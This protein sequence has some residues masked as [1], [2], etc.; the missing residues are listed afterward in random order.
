MTLP[1]FKILHRVSTQLAGMDFSWRTKIGA[2]FIITHGWGLVVNE[3]SHIGKNVTLFHG[4]TLG[5]NGRKGTDGKITIGYP[6]LEDEV[7]VGPNA[8]IVGGVTIG[9][10]SRIAAGAFVTESL[11]PYSL[12][13]G[14]PAKIIKPNCKPDVDNPAPL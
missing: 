6:I 3:N 13:S 9:R 14:N 12:V 4:V 1:L 11:P 7:W 10:G 8:V 2:G 5:Q